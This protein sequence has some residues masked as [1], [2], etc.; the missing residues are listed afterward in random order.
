VTWTAGFQTGDIVAA[1][2]DG[3]RFRVETSLDYEE[4]LVSALDGDT[5]G[6]SGS[7]LADEV[8][9]LERPT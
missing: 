6:Q 8:R 9:L 1:V 5:A 4:L 7:V 3:Q 2:D